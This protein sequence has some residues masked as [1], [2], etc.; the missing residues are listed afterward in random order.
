M[1][2]HHLTLFLEKEKTAAPELS[3]PSLLSFCFLVL[4]L[5]RVFL[6]LTPFR[7]PPGRVVFTGAV[8]HTDAAAAAVV[9]PNI[10]VFAGREVHRR[11]AV[12]TGIVG[13]RQGTVPRATKVNNHKQLTH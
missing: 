11:G 4:L 6:M 5:L 2:E 3:T 9:V 12:H 7:A 13:Q 1:L 8:V 10:V